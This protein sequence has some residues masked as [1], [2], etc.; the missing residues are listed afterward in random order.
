MIAYIG[1]DYFVYTR[2]ESEHAMHIEDT[3]I[4][5]SAISLLREENERRTAEG[6]STGVYVLTLG[7]QQNEADSERLRGYAALMGYTPVSAPEEASLILINTCAIREHAEQRALSLIGRM[8]HE[9]AARRDV[10]IGVVGCMAAEPHRVEELRKRYP[11]VDFTMDPASMES[12]PLLILDRKR[13]KPRRFLTGDTCPPVTEGIPVVRDS[14]HRAYVSIMYGC[15]N[16]CSYCIVPYVR[17]RERSRDAAAVESEV[18]ELVS[19]GYRE[20]TLLGQNVNSYRGGV[21]FATLLSRLDAIPGEFVLRFMTSHPKDVSDD[22]IRVIAEGTH[23]ERHF[24]LPVQ[25][26]NDRILAAMNRH[27]SLEQYMTVVKKLRAAMPDIVLTTDVIV[28]FPSETEEEF[29]DT[30]RLLDRV[31]FDMVFS[32][33]YSPRA[34]T[35]AAQRE[36]FV[37]AEVQS[38]RFSRLLRAQDG[39]ALERAKSYVGKI[40]RVLVDAPG[41][42]NGLAKG[43]T[44]GGKLVHFDADAACVGSFLW[45]EID[46]AEPYAL[47]GTVKK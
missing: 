33:I 20:I 16:F 32:F 13:G 8:K 35:P 3:P 46:R 36:D 4:L 7:C 31:R 28:G 26:G 11:Y 29:E 19:R 41:D 10:L 39:Y 1:N 27:Y 15:N 18:R 24:H 17:G 6:L 23:I 38:E 9:K 14:D 44:S 40:V 45:V 47:Y 30:L 42:K 25:S 12:L 5:S 2:E 37:P 22:L 21:D 34:G 43:R